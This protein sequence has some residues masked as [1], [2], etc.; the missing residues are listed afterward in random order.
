MYAISVENSELKDATSSRDFI[1]TESAERP[2][3]SPKSRLKTA[4]KGIPRHK[5]VQTIDEF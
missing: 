4:Q 1:A 5:K 2:T 3:A